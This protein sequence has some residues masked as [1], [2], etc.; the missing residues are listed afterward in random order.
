MSLGFLANLFMLMCILT[1]RLMTQGLEK[2]IKELEDTIKDK[3]PK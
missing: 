2:R 3:E 1:E